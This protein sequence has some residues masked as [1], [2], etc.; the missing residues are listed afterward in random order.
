MK[1]SLQ[2][3][4][5]QNF[6]A[7]REFSLD[8]DGRHLLVY[9]ENGAGKSSL[10]WALY[11]FL[12]SARKPKDTIAKYFD[13]ADP[14]NLLN[15]HE[16]DSTATPGEIALTLRDIAT[17][18]DTTYR[19][20]QTNHETHAHPIIVKGDL[21]SDF[22]TY[23]FFFGFSHFRNSANFDL[24]P[25]FEREILPFCV[26]RGGKPGALADRWNEL[27]DTSPNPN[28]YSGTAGA[29]AFRIFDENLKSYTD[30]L[31]SVVDEISAA[32]QVF[33]DTNF[34][35]KDSAKI[36]LKLTITK[37]AYY[38]KRSGVKMPPVLRF[39]IQADGIEVKKPQSFLNEAKMTQLALSVRFAASV[40]NL[41][42]S[43]L[44]LLVL[45]DLLVSLDMSN[46]MKVVKIL[47]T[48][49]SLENYQKIILTHDYGFFQEFRRNIG[50]N[51]PDWSFVQLVGDPATA[52][53][54][55]VVKSERQKAEEYLHGHRLDEAA[56]CLRK[57]C[58]DTAKR[59][60]GKAEVVPTKEFLG[61]AAALSSARNKVLEEFPTDFYEKIVRNTPE[62]HRA[63]LVAT[64]DNDLDDDATLDPA[65]RGRL[66]TNR[67]RLRLLLGEEQ[68]ER[69][70]QIK[71]ID[72]ILACTAR[73]L[74]PAAHSGDSP[75]YEKEVQD[76]LVLVTQL[77]TTLT[78]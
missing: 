55:Q 26:T 40:V 8:F 7:F 72:E 71:L 31:S 46:R 3:I 69:L 4:E 60:I 34:A 23:R 62:Q 41:H 24:W 15:I 58:E 56:L 5:I 50:S 42:E 19:I 70:R 33:Y 57:V 1:N 21:A 37:D 36:T 18:K 11:T 13:P 59:F 38:S 6:K 76:A 43:E 68:V 67:N 66:K 73:V 61:L 16:K 74:N 10:Y 78:S 22:I 2:K 44:K 48:D 47:L 39:G 32:A 27:K 35:E 75:L 49:K 20:N 63:R 29:K 9:G 53:T 12:Q 54:C 45:D 30:S 51:H 65:T 52:I 14:Q 28:S 25:L 17:D 64:S 77:E